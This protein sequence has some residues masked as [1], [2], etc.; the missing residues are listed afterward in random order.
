M[1]VALGPEARP[2]Q[3]W[4]GRQ[5]FG[6]VTEREKETAFWFRAHANGITF[7]FS[8]DEWKAVQELFR[9]AWEMPEVRIAWDA[10]SLD[11]GEL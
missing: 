3:R 1:L 7:G 4:D 11:Y 10:M 9:R 6:Y 8:G 2:P 5:F